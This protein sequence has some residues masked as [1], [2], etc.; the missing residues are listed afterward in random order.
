MG[1]TPV[2]AQNNQGMMGEAQA[3]IQAVMGRA[4]EDWERGDPEE[5]S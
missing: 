4:Q 1:E 2:T 3:V 5:G